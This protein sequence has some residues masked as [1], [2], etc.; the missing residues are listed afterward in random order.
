MATKLAPAPA[1]VAPPAPVPLSA[2]HRASASARGFNID[3]V[4]GQLRQGLSEAHHALYAII[5]A[6]PDGDPNL[7]ALQSLRRRLL[8]FA[9][10]IDLFSPAPVRS[11]TIYGG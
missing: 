9:G 2:E 8:T 7:A 4:V 6:A 11:H 10:E 5:G 3:G 1:P